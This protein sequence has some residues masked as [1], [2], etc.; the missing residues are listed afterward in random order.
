M[1]GGGGDLSQLFHPSMLG[2][3]NN[4]FF[5]QIVNNTGTKLAPPVRIG[6]SPFS[7]AQ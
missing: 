1:S 6:V 4:Y 2:K 5:W 3:N 7:M